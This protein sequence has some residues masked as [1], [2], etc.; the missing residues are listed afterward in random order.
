MYFQNHVVETAEELLEILNLRGSFQLV[1][2]VAAFH[3][4]HTL[5][6]L[7]DGDGNVAVGVE[8]HGGDKGKSKQIE[9]QQPP[10]RSAEL[11]QKIRGRTKQ[12]Q[13]ADFRNCVTFHNQAG[14]NV[15]GQAGAAG[16]KVRLAGINDGA[17]Q[18]GQGKATVLNKAGIGIQAL[19]QRFGTH[20]CADPDL[21]Y[22]II[23]HQPGFAVA[24]NRKPGISG[25]GRR[26]HQVLI[27]EIAA[28]GGWAVAQRG[29]QFVTVRAVKEIEITGFYIANAVLQ[30]GQDILLGQVAAQRAAGIVILGAGGQRDQFQRARVDFVHLAADLFRIDLRCAGKALPKIAQH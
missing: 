5:G 27:P 20:G 14:R 26:Q 12:Q 15:T 29:Q 24:G 30:A 9:Q 17:I 18:P 28:A 7:L 6:Q 16:H 11:V 19:Q 8:Q 2:P 22:I 3:L 4:A 10:E 25:L 21:G 1:I 23:A 13:S